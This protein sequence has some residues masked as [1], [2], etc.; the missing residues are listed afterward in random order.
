MN[1]DMIQPEDHKVSRTINLSESYFKSQWGKQVFNVK[2]L[3]GP[4]VSY[5]FWKTFLG[6][7]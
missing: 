3:W 7:S 5:A 6:H 2:N 4:C 1:H